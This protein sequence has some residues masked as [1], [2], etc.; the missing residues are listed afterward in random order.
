MSSLGALRTE[1]TPTAV[2]CNIQEGL[3]Y[4]E[5]DQHVLNSYPYI[6]QKN[7][8]DAY[9]Y[10][11]LIFKSDNKNNW[12]EIKYWLM[13]AT[14]SNDQLLIPELISKK[15]MK[16]VKIWDWDK[17]ASH[18]FF[19]YFIWLSQYLMICFVSILWFRKY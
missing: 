16:K 9:F 1:A 2:N 12:S 6:F 14:T 17:E 10:V 11:K 3:H 15:L 18:T 19:H 8:N 7:V 5:S 4:T 13:I